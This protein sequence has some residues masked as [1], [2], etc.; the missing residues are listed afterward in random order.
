[1]VSLLNDFLKRQEELYLEYLFQLG[2]DEISE[3]FKTQIKSKT[4][5]NIDLVVRGIIE[6][7]FANSDISCVTTIKNSVDNFLNNFRQGE[8]G[9]NDSLINHFE[10]F[11]QPILKEIIDI[12]N[13]FFSLIH[14]FNVTSN[15]FIY[16]S[17]EL[18]STKFQELVEMAEYCNLFI[19]EYSIVDEI[20]FYEKLNSSLKRTALSHKRYPFRNLTIYEH[21]IKFLSYKWLKRRKYDVSI[22]KKHLGDSYNE[23]YVFGN[24]IVDLDKKVLIG[25]PYYEVYKDWINKIDFHYFDDIEKID[26]DAFL[27]NVD[28]NDSYDLHFLV[29]LYKDYE[30]NLVELKKL[31]EYYKK[32]PT[33]LLSKN[34]KQKNLLYFYNNYFSKL[35]EESNEDSKEIKEKFNEITTIYKNKSNNN[36]FIY[37]KYLNLKIKESQKFIKEKEIGKID[38]VYLNDLLSICRNH[39]EWTK[40]SLNRLYDFDYKNC[41]IT[42]SALL[43]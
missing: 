18:I 33:H 34:S 22:L 11:F 23:K 31:E 14:P 8:V 38:L 28:Y 13:Q 26:A 12:I 40:A 5:A 6:G 37:Y 42:R 20:S 43:N 35:E 36:F 15:H 16:H 25:E 2:S 4:A 1:V 24:N 41:I 39:F 27:E 17:Q 30:P 29:K 32:Y 7:R 19:L 21:K 10:L 3:L 9:G